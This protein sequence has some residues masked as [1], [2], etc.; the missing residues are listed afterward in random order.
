M[1]TTP[2]PPP[3]VV[4]VPRHC[5]MFP[6]EQS[7]PQ[8][9]TTDLNNQISTEL[10]RVPFPITRFAPACGTRSGFLL[11]L[12]PLTPLRHSDSSLSLDTRLW[13]AFLCLCQGPPAPPQAG[14]WPNLPLPGCVGITGVMSPCLPRKG[15]TKDGVPKDVQ[16]HPQLGLWVDFCLFLLLLPASEVFVF[17]K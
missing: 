4:T 12:P 2:A 1:P 17:T 10:V 14:V 11:L 15:G 9:R 7:H 6:G 16:P 5:Q 13:T 8:L 3:P